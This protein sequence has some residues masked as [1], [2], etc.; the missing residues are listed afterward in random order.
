VTRDDGVV[1]A[2]QWDFEDGMTMFSVFWQAAEAV[3]MEA[4]A[5]QRQEMARP[6]PVTI[7]DLR[8]LWEACGL[9]H[10]TTATLELS[11]EFASFEDYWRPFLGGSTPT[12]RFAARLDM[13]TGCAL[14]RMLRDRLGAFEQAGSFVLPARA[15]AVKGAK[16]IGA[17]S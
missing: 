3:E 12:S 17:R 15:W 6:R 1:A 5:R 13:E 4:V 11:M 7:D 14:S 9:A 2:C 8:A 10:V 16:G